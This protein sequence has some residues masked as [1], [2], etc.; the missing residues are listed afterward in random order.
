MQRVTRKARAGPEKLHRS[1]VGRGEKALGARCHGINLKSDKGKH[2]Y[3][4][5]RDHQ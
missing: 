2:A 1:P 4:T 5:S 3:L